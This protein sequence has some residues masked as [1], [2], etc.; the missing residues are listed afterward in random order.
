MEIE[1]EKFRLEYK[2]HKIFQGRRI[3]TRV[4]RVS[5]NNDKFLG[6]IG[7]PCTDD[8]GR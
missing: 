5:G 4:G 2:V 3:K 6:L 1:P 8:G 7:V